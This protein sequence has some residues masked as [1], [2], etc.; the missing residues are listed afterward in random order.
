[1]A[2]SGG[3]AGAETAAG[4]ELV[5]SSATAGA[6]EGDGPGRRRL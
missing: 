2:S 3:G 5:G 1:M 6:L 4:E